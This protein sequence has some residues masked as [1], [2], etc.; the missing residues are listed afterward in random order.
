MGFRAG[1]R[2]QGGCWQWPEG[3]SAVFHPTPFGSELRGSQGGGGPEI[4][5]GV[6]INL[7]ALAGLGSPLGFPSAADV[8]AVVLTMDVLPLAPGL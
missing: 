2:T 5:V 3:N 4:V 6:S 8:V 7:K 1:F